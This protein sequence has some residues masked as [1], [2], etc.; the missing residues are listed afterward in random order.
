MDFL[1]SIMFFVFAIIIFIVVFN[2]VRVNAQLKKSTY[3]RQ[4]EIHS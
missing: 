3:G 2:L 4:V 1:L